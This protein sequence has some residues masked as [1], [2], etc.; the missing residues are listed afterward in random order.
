MS[1]AHEL[2]VL[3]RELTSV[4][5]EAAALRARATQI[6][7]GCEVAETLQTLMEEI[8]SL[9]H[10]RAVQVRMEKLFLYDELSRVNATIVGLQNSEH[11]LATQLLEEGIPQSQVDAA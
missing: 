2:A 10:A 9:N 8:F 5:S 4:R 3:M 1:G 6:S 7:R 11:D